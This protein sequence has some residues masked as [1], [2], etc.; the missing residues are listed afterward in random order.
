MLNLIIIIIFVCYFHGEIFF[1][2]KIFFY[3]NRCPL[4]TNS[5]KLH[6]EEVEKRAKEAKEKL[7]PKVQ[8]KHDPTKDIPKVRIFLFFYY[9]NKDKNS[10]TC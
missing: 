6:A 7:D 2:K 1:N 3:N 10:N 5:L 4:W 8:L 9:P